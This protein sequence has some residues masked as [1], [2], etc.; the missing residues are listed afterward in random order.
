M[1]AGEVTENLCLSRI[2]WEKR[3]KICALVDT[4]RNGSNISMLSV[5]AICAMAKP[6]YIAMQ[7]GG[8]VRT[9]IA[10]GALTMADLYDLSHITITLVEIDMTG[11][12]TETFLEDALDY[13]PQPDRST[14]PF[15]IVQFFAGITT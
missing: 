13:A 11:A 8:C 14:A 4:L 2:L 5:D 12:E 1:K 3:S 7:S 9:D 6:S 15:H 10:M